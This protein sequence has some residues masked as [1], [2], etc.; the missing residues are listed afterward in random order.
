RSA[1]IEC[2]DTRKRSTARSPSSAATAMSA[3]E[4]FLGYDG[5]D[6]ARID[7]R[8]QLQ[9]DF[10]LAEFAKGARLGQAHL[11]AL[12]FRAGGRDGIGNR[13]G[14]DRAVELAFAPGT[15]LDLEALAIEGVLAP[16]GPRQ[17]VG[18]L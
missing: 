9:L 17:L 8:V 4:L 2:G 1:S 3:P 13:G 18:G 10:E 15:R 6:N 11:A 16:L 12:D 5:N 7:V 14:A